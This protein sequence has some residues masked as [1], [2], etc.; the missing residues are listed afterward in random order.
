MKRRLISAGDSQGRRNRRSSSAGA[1]LVELALT[2]PILLLIAIGIWDFGSAFAMKQKLTNA[3]RGA[4]RVMVSTPFMNPANPTGCTTAVP[5]SVVSAATSV[6]DYLTNANLDG[7][8]ITPSSPTNNPSVGSC[9]WTWTS[10]PSNSTT[11]NYYKL[12]IIGNVWIETDGTVVPFTASSGTAGSVLGTQVTLEYPVNWNWA[13]VF[14][15][16][17]FGHEIVTTVTMVNI[18]G[19]CQ[20]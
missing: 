20:Q 11:S 9:E 5:C 10:S 2:V 3:A 4:A 17:S 15:A 1:Q 14:P 7:S 18:G 13:A 16:G 8:W 19:G 12:D 6:Q